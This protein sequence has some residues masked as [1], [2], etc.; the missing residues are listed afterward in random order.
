[1][2]CVFA[3]VVRPPTW[4]VAVSSGAAAVPVTVAACVRPE[5]PDTLNVL[6]DPGT[7]NRHSPEVTTGPGGVPPVA[8]NTM[9]SSVQ[10]CA[11]S[12]SIAVWSVEKRWL[13]SL[14]PGGG[15]K[16]L[17][18]ARQTGLRGFAHRRLAGN[19]M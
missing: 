11:T 7:G 13:P 5:P 15:R 9:P 1:M 18:Y 4:V 17:L 16:P 10:P 12:C 19:W 8:Q 2:Y 14:N 6:L 3:T